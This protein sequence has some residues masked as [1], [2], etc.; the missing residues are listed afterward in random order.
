[1]LPQAQMFITAPTS[2][3]LLKPPSVIFG[4]WAKISGSPSNLHCFFPDTNDQPHIITGQTIMHSSTIKGV[5][6]ES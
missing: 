2:Q 3:T 6:L 5:T 1:M 4:F